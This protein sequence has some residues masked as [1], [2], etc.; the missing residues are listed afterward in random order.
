MDLVPFLPPVFPE[1]KEWT[2]EYEDAEIPVLWGR[3]KEEVC[4][5]IEKSGLLQQENEPKRPKLFEANDLKNVEIWLI[6]VFPAS[7]EMVVER[8]VSY[9]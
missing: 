8:V 3:V 1:D 6:L 9:G 7:A 4:S 2:L 5:R